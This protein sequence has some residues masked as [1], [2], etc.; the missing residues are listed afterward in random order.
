MLS[1]GLSWHYTHAETYKQEKHPH[2]QNKTVLIF[3]KGV[4]ETG[5]DF[6]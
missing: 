6:V 1:S 2:P 4:Q 5:I 3:F